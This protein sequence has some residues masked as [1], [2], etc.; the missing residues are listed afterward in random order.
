MLA[1][2]IL[3]GFGVLVYRTGQQAGAGTLRRDSWFA[4]RSAWAT[5][6]DEAWDLSHRVVAPYMRAA[7]TI[8]IVGGIA[9]VPF[10]LG[11]VAESDIPTAVISIVAGGSLIGVLVVGAFRAR[12]AVQNLPGD[13]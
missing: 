9:L 5:K 7:G 3:F 13:D 8:G 4:F 11:A 6:S 2:F 1:A 12:Q 10:S